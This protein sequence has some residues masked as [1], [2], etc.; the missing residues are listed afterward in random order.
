MLLIQRDKP[1]YERK[2]A[3]PGGFMDM[4]ETLEEA[5]HRELH[6]E[7]G[8]RDTKLVQMCTVS[9]LGRDPRG[10]T[11]TT[12][13]FGIVNQH[14]QQ[15]TGM[16]DARDAQWFAISDLPP[17]AFDHD[18]IIEMAKQFYQQGHYKNPI[19]IHS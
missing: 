16:D 3:F 10:R 4:D 19:E 6:E 15:A 13:Y 12:V 1:P 9:K 2:W 14:K 18:D 17:L 8:L 11:I 5:A 7:T